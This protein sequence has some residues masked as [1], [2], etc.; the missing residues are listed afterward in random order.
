MGLAGKN[1]ASRGIYAVDVTMPTYDA[2]LVYPMQ[3]GVT[4]NP[5]D[6]YKLAWTLVPIERTDEQLAAKLAEIKTAKLAD[7]KAGANAALEPLAAAYP[8]REVQSW[9]QQIAEAAGV[10][11]NSAAD[12]PLLR[13]MAAERPS[14]GDTVEDRVAELA[15]R[16][17][18]NA[19]AW[20]TMAGP[21]IGKRQA[22]EDAVGAATT[23]E[24]VIG[25]VV[26]FTGAGSDEATTSPMAS[27]ADYAPI[28]SSAEAAS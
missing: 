2:V 14:L 26:D 22:L 20:S 18:A 5:T 10:A 4:G 9:P 24:D 15:R 11:A 3:N 6:G 25:V 13:S 21:V 1:L 28:D 27:E 12:V 17:L 8:D 23:L 19:A 7:I 16:I